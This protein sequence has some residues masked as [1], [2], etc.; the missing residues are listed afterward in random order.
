MS[1]VSF[2]DLETYR[3]EVFIQED[4]L[5]KSVMPEAVALGLPPVSVNPDAGMTL[6]LLA[7]MIGARKILEFGA[8]AG[9]SAIWLARA[10][11]REGRLISL[12]LDPKHARIARANLARAR[13]ADRAEVRAGSALQMMAEVSAEAPF[14]MVFIDADKESYPRYL[15]FALD[16]VRLGGLI[17]ADNADGH[18]HVH[19]NLEPGDGR[20]GIQTYNRR[21]ASDRRLVS[22]ALPIGGWLAVSVKVEE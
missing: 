13:L 20:R 2:P 21:V 10:L 1:E 8:L 14:D 4:P 22:H 12:E 19:E 6:H 18:G 3:R 11:P 7:R 15:D 9:Y 5:L 16:H 17:V